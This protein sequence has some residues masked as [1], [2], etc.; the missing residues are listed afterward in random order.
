MSETIAII[1]AIG[2]AVMWSIS[3]HIDKYLVKNSSRDAEK[4]IKGL[5]VFSSF[6]I[7]LIA[8]P[9]CFALAN[10]N[11]AM[12]WQNILISIA[13]GMIYIMSTSLYL[14]AMKKNDAT[15]VV[16][17]FQLIPVFLYIPSVVF[18]GESFTLRQLI[19]AIIILAAAIRIGISPQKG[20]REGKYKAMLL[21][22]A[23]VIC[24]SIYYMMMDYVIRQESYFACLSWYQVGLITTGTIMLC[25]KGSRKAFRSIIKRNGKAF[26]GINLLN[27]GFN[28]TG[29]VFEHVANSVLPIA[30]VNLISGLQGAITFIIGIIGT[31]LSPK[32]FSE[33]I[34]R[35]TFVVKTVCILLS[36]VG[37]VLIF[38]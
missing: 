4:N 31:K 13:A 27:E 25:M 2:A 28:E 17:M 10:F 20:R 30:L 35:K 29:V 23:S 15:M 11:I 6:V 19:G 34:D 9:I 8:F 18:Y 38:V 5:L 3:G 22:L 21:A 24:I 16:M 12:S 32:H 14:K 33:K 26:V 7:G 1:L 36:I 37:L